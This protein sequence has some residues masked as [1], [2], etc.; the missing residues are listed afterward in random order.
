VFIYR[1]TIIHDLL[2]RANELRFG[3]KSAF[4]P[5][6]WESSTGSRLEE[7]EKWQSAS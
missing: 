5:F 4:F 6:Y 3:A 1:N 2:L 7:T